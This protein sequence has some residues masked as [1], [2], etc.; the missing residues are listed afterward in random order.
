MTFATAVDEVLRVVRSEAFAETEASRQALADL[1]LAT[2]VR[3]ALRSEPK[4]RGVQLT[5]SAERG[6]VTLSGVVSDAILCSQAERVAG[7]TEGVS[8]LVNTLRVGSAI[9]ARYA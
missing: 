8:G 4:T 6:R 2:K 3:A 1:A 7:Q 5:V 9:R